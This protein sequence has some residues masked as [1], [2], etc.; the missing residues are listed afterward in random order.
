MFGLQH[1]LKRPI[2]GEKTLLILLTALT[3]FSTINANP[4]NDN[5]STFI[6]KLVD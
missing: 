4:V 1:L 3:F 2:I 6:G 5:D